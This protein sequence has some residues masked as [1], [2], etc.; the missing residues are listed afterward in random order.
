MRACPGTR[1]PTPTT[2]SPSARTPT[3]APGHQATLR[4]LAA[5]LHTLAPQEGFLPTHLSDVTLMR[6][7]R[8]CDPVAV[9]QEPSF[10][11]ALQGV[12]RGYLDGEVLRY[13]GGQCLVVSVPMHFACDT[14]VQAPEAPMLA[15]SVRIDLDTV[16]E[17][18]NRLAGMG[19]T[20]A[21]PSH[22]RAMSVMDMGPRELDWCDRLLD[23]L[24]SRADAA[25]LGP[26]LVR[27]L[28][29]R[30]LTSPA[31]IC[32]RALANWHGKLGA[33]HRSIERM[34]TDYTQ[35]LQ[36]AAL[37]QDAAMSASS[38]HA[39]F[40]AVTG[41]SPMQYLKAVRLHRAREL[42]TVDGRRATEV[43]F[44][45]GYQSPSQFSKEYK[46]FFGRSPS[47]ARE[48]LASP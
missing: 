44:D 8:S 7:D 21:P 5:K 40:K 10:V 29:Y 20:A 28:H 26:Q 2:M 27:E 4:A 41:Q 17:M 30:V 23:A 12:K 46:R 35:D 16:R 39:S 34:R 38:Y 15:L 36:V 14:V 22:A 37:A 48:P 47:Q 42:L 32:L 11:I 3:R 33:I 31:G 1:S 18:A 19:L 24:S 43:A 13:E 25:I 9:L 45:V 6:V